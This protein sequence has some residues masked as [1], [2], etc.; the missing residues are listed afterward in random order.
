MTMNFRAQALLAAAVLSAGALC[1]AQ[2][3]GEATYKAKCAMCHGAA[4]VPNPAMAKSMGIKASSDADIKKLTAAQMIASVKA[5]K[6]KMPSFKDK[7]SDAE[8]KE[9]VAF[10]RGLK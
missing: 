3:S 5:G 8:I 7:L 4:G 10:Y 9:V 1:F 2:S 6:G